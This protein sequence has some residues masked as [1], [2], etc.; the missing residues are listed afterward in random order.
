MC[1]IPSS[2]YATLSG[3]EEAQ[4]TFWGAASN[5][6]LR[7]R[8]LRVVDVG[9]GSTELISGA[10]SVITNMHSIDIGHVRLTETLKIT[11]PI[12]DSKIR[13]LTN[14]VN[15]KLRGE[16]LAAA[17]EDE[18]L[19]GVGGTFTTLAQIDMAMEKYDADRIQGYGMARETISALREKM[20]NVALPDRRRI[21]GLSPTRADV[22]VA[23]VAIVENIMQELRFDE[24]TVSTRGLRHGVLVQ[25]MQAG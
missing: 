2:N 17:D 10:S 1:N 6:E 7:R 3:E 16:H 18:M 14:H 19:V 25:K 12:A 5:Q 4:Y 24:V 11:D 15:E 8:K 22:I 20:Q 13:E 23:G 21:S 9:G